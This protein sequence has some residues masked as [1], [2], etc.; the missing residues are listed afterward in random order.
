MSKVQEI[1]KDILGY[2]GYYRVST[3]GRIKSRMRLRLLRNAHRNSY[4]IQ[5][6]RDQIRGQYINK[7]G[8][9]VVVLSNGNRTNPIPVHRL[10]AG[11]FIENPENKPCVN[12]INSMRNDNHVSNLEWCTQK[13]N[14]QHAAKSGRL[15]HK[16]TRRKKENK[17]VDTV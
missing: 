5:V 12:H 9:P 1:W 6:L 8:Y 2:E 3:N 11:A 17:I 16:L 15:C 10:V 4:Y 13:E 7:A 14:M